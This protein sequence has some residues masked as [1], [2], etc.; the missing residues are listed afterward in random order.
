MKTTAIYNGITMQD[1]NTESISHRVERDKTGSDPIYVELTIVGTAVVHNIY[2]STLGLE[3]PP[4]TDLPLGF[5]LIID[6]LL[7]PKRRFEMLIGSRSFLSIVPAHAAAPGL[8]SQRQDINNGPRTSVRIARIVSGMTM[9]IEFTIVLCLPYCDRPGGSRGGV[10]NFR[11]WSSEELDSEFYTTRTYNGRIRVKHAGLNVFHEL[12]NNFLLPPLAKGCERK[13]IVVRESQD[14]LE[15][16]FTITDKEVYACA[17]H[18]AITWD[19]H[20]TQ[21]VQAAH[22]TMESQV[23]VVLRGQKNVDKRKLISLAFAIGND[24]LHHL[25]AEAE[26]NIIPMSMVLDDHVSGNEVTFSCSVY[27]ALDGVV[28]GVKYGFRRSIGSPI[29][30]PNYDKEYQL[31]GVDTSSL[32]GILTGVFMDQ[33]PCHV[34]AMPTCS[35]D[36]SV[37]RYNYGRC[38]VVVIENATLPPYQTKYDTKDN[39]KGAYIY[40]KLENDWWGDSGRV[41]LPMGTDSRGGRSSNKMVSLYKEQQYRD[42]FIDAKRINVPPVMPTPEDFADTNARQMRIVEYQVSPS[43]KQLSADA[44][45]TIDGSSAFF[46]FSADKPYKPGLGDLPTGTVPVFNDTRPYSNVVPAQ[47]FESQSLVNAILRGG[48]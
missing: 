30:L 28:D 44:R 14:K 25:D 27:E 16:E 19:C 5:N 8:Q 10:I 40:Y 24:R 7:Q 15:A 26:G 22:G 29:L 6:D 45:K 9:T 1:W 31:Q 36:Q 32:S 13:S 43:A 18:P 17:P 11:Y 39:R 33:D 20:H 2:N 12:R 41:A 3:L 35:N 23:N 34:A 48:Q 4:G 21:T 47:Y 46:R 38:G 42:V 37:R